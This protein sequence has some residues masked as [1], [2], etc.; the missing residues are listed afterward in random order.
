[1]ILFWRRLDLAGLE[2][3]ALDAGSDAVSATS[4][5]L[6]LE[7]GGYRLD[8]VWDLDPGWRTRQVSLVRTDA[9]GRRSIRLERA[10]D[11]WTVDDVPRADLD[12]ALEADLSATPFSN[13][14]VVRRMP[15]GADLTLDVAYL[16]VGAMTV[17][18]S[19]QRYV[20]RGRGRLRYVDLGLSAGFEADLDVDAAGLVLRYGS[21]FAREQPVDGR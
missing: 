13:S 6:G 20:R 19:R 15:P 12:G 16:D 10:G 3:L 18:R 14:M 9:A 5:V 2:R 7:A 11:G 1:M 17:A 4:T 21:L 8:Y